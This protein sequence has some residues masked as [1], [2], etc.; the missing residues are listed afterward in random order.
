MEKPNH[1]DYPHTDA[2]L[3]AYDRDMARYNRIQKGPMIGTEFADTVENV[4]GTGVEKLLQIPG[5]AP[6]LQF[7]G[8][9]V[10]VVDQI[11]TNDPGTGG[12]LYRGYKDVRSAAETGFGDLA[13]S[14]GVD[15]R[16]G[17]FGGGE[18]VD[19]A[20][21]AGTGA[22]AKRVVNVI[23]ML[24]PPGMT[25]Q[26]AT[27]GA[28]V[29]PQLVAGAIP[30][31]PQI[32]RTFAKGAVVMKAVTA[33]DRPTLETVG[34]ETG[35]NIVTPEQGRRLIRR[36]TEIERLKGSIQQNNEQ[37][38]AL[39]ELQGD[40]DNLRIFLDDN[41]EVKQLMAMYEGRP[42]QIEKVTN[43]LR[44]RRIGAQESLSRQQSNVL[45]FDESD[46]NFFRSK[47]GLVAKRDE[48]VRRGITGYLEQH[49]LFPKGIS[50]AFFG[51]MDDLI[52]RGLAEKD[53]LILMAEYAV[54]RGQRTGDVRSN[55]ANMAKDPHNELH[56]MLRA[57]G[58]ELGKTDYV[59]SLKDVKNVDELLRRWREM[60]DTDV[61]YNIDTAKVWEPLDDLI[62]EVR[63]YK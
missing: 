3:D 23:D 6:T 47:A 16:Y 11:M 50:A 45:P 63:A 30:A 9:V 41:P 27:A 37:L 46:P 39:L 18:L 54:K 36:D 26:L 61:A 29:S 44:E 15:R 32:E 5:A 53:D 31:P 19:W 34:V 42:N 14:V 12:L 25:R 52:S 59:R 21:T 22:V 13:E 62:K 43:R 57:S 49:H 1:L 20:A 8:G 4:V 10:S 55:I 40:P 58:A 17:E 60:L 33:T 51:K 38:D 7:V 28:G 35:E 24:P 2:G 56:T 48:E